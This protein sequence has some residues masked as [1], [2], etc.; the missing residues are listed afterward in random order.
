MAT[1]DYSPIIMVTD[2]VRKERIN[3]SVIKEREGEYFHY[4]HDHFF[5]CCLVLKYVKVVERQ[6]G[7]NLFYTML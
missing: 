7:Y 3:V 2:N 1:K 5:Y 6:S 4:C